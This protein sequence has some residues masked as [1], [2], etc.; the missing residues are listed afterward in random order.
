MFNVSSGAAE[1][2]FLIGDLIES[3]VDPTKCY[4]A[5]HIKG[6]QDNAF[7]LADGS[8]GWFRLNP[9]QYGASASGEQTPIWSPFATIALGGGCGA[10]ASIEVSPGVKQMLVS[11][12]TGTGPIFN[13][14]INTFQDNN[15]SYTWNA[16]IGSLMLALPGKLAEIESITTEMTA[17]TANQCNVAVLIDE[18]APSLEV[19]F[20]DIT[21]IGNNPTPDPPQLFG[22]EPSESVLSNR[23]YLSPG[24]VPPIGR[25]MQIQLSGAATPTKDELLALTVRGCIIEEQS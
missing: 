7:Y 5:R 14:D 15:D 11:Q 4:L 10:I 22:G 17:A 12:A 8:T 3:P 23:F 24:T 19:P 9:N 21:N 16:T 13:R 2:G 6:S 1:I 18:I 20:E 25:H